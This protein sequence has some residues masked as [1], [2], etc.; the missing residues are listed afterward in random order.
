M[1]SPVY[2]QVADALERELARRKPGTQ[3]ASEHALARRYAINRLTVRAAL[4]ELERRNVVRRAQGRRASVADRIDY[5]IGP[6]DP[7]SWTRSV[8]AGGGTPRSETVTLRRRRAPAPVRRVLRVGPS[9]ATLFLARRRYANEVLAAYA[10]TWLPADLVPDLAGVLAAEG[11]LFDALQRVYRLQPVRA[12]TRAEFV[13]APAP[14][15]RMLDS[16][17]RPFVFALNGQTESAHLGR[18]VEATTSWLRA[19]CFRVVFALGPQ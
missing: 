8:V 9:E 10:E 11:S 6:A 4:G 14:V 1:E 7:P 5:R 17:E 16:D 19:D 12:A 18:V 15:A 3:L 2:L 13:V